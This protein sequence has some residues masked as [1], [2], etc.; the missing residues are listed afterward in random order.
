MS[1]IGRRLS[2]HSRQGLPVLRPQAGR[3]SG[4][5]DRARSPARMASTAP[6]R[7]DSALVS[8]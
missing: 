4:L 8:G 7:C 5:P 2:A 3:V 1:G 6:I